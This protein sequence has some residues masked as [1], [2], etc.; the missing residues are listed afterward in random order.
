MFITFISW[1]FWLLNLLICSTLSYKILNEP[2]GQALFA[3][4]HGKS[5]PLFYWAR[6]R[7]LC[8]FPVET[9]RGDVIAYLAKKY[10]HKTVRFLE[11]GTPLE[12]SK[13]L[14]KLIQIVANGYGAAVA[15]DGPPRPLIY[16]TARPGILYLSQK[17][18]V[19]VVPAGIK[20][21][22]KIALF[23]RWDR[24]EIP[25]PWSEV[26]INFGRPFVA[27]EKTTTRELEE[28]LLLLGGESQS[29]AGQP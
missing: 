13:N 19:P 1:F 2:K 6:H 8:L 25:L 4:W 9:W 11:K 24:Y 3:V 15:V 7:K 17:T 18:G 12:R 26:E 10:G 23:W 21:K 16:H 28:L 29:A 5:F 14:E 20:M 22:R 27:G